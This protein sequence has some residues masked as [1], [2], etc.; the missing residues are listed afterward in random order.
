M[1]F[2]LSRFGSR[3]LQGARADIGSDPFL[4][5]WEWEVGFEP[6][7]SYGLWFERFNKV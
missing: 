6:T 1:G 4:R 3:R 7:Y 5:T 2:E